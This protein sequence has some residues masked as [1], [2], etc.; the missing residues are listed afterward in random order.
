ME[1]RQENE[2]YKNIV[3]DCLM[4]KYGLSINEAE[5]AM[6]DGYHL[7]EKLNRFMHPS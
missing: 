6:E 4:N 3:R 1:N 2:S 5:D 7:T